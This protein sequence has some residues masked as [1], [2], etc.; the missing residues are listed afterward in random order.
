MSI[1]FSNKYLLLVGLFIF[2][3]TGN[4]N[5]QDEPRQ[6]LGILEIPDSLNKARFWGV[7]STLAVGYTGVVVGLNRAW[8]ANYERGRFH[9]FNDMGEWQD[10]DKMGHFFTAYF[11]AKLGSKI[12]RWTGVDERKSAYAGVALATVFQST[13]EVLDG[14][15]EKW[16]FSWGDIAFN[17]AGA[18]LFLG[19]ELA[20]K[21]QRIQLKISTFR[22]K[23]DNTPIES[24]NMPGVYSSLE[25]RSLDLYGSWFGE[26]FL[27][28]YNAMTIWASANI[29]SFIKKEDS[30]F[31]KWL[32]IAVGYGAENMYAGFD[33]QWT[34]EETGASYRLDPEVH[35]RYRQFFLSFDVDLTR[36][37]VKNRFLKTLF[38]IL[39]II[40]IPAP[41]LEVNTLGKV[42]LR[43]IYF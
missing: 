3:L 23:L 18:G 40:K 34:D 22:G 41:A 31:P 32:N 24:Y 4:L 37:P 10:M 38:S 17:T 16:G 28:D 9:N 25:E 27:K 15:S 7:N 42:K 14:F 30:R 1:F 2:S 8:Y 43:P 26:L 5:A 19:Q 29:S 11:E 12:F 33:Y 35:P 39:N 13:I 36:I 21:E 6:K 20:W